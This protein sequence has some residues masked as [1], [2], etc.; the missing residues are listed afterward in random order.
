MRLAEL[1]TLT[2]VGLAALGTAQAQDGVSRKSSPLVIFERQDAPGKVD[3]FKISEALRIAMQEL[4]VPAQALPSFV[5]FHISETEAELFGVK[6]TSIWRTGRENGIRYEVWIVGEPNDE[7][8][9]KLA[10]IFLERHFG[11]TVEGAERKRVVH[12]VTD[13]LAGTVSVERLRK[14][15]PPAIRSALRVYRP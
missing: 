6:V 8:Y 11:L 7:A 9:A 15:G 14:D 4:R 10:E 12:A 3:E 13:A 2:F 5:I 1:G